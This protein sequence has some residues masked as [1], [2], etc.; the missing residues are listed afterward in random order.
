[1]VREG[2]GRKQAQS[3]AHLLEMFTGPLGEWLDDH[4]DR[5]LVR[6]FFLALAAMVR[7]RHSRSGLLLSELRAHILSP[8]KAPAG[9]NVNGG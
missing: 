8:D 2:E 5:R 9:T 4:L 3:V 1:M 6:T 7:L